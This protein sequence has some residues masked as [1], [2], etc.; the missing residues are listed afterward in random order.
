MT[1]WPNG[2]DRDGAA[3]ADYDFHQYLAACEM[4]RGLAEGIRE[5]DPAAKRIIDCAGWL[6]FG[7]M[8]DPDVPGILEQARQMGLALEPMQTTFVLSRN[9]VAPAPRSTLARWRRRLFIVLARN[10]VPAE[11][12]FRLPANRV[13]ELGMKIEI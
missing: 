11:E 10:A 8:E 13:V 5:G 7:F 6:H 12:F 4:L 3:R 9:L 1:K 2:G